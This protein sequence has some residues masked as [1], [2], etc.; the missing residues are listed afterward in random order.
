M[1]EGITAPGVGSLPTVDY[2]SELRQVTEERY[3]LPVKCHNC[4][5]R[6]VGE[7]PYGERR[8]D[9]GRCP[10]C[11]AWGFGF[12]WGDMQELYAPPS[13]EG[14]SVEPGPMAAT[15]E[16]LLELV[17]GLLALADA[18]E[19]A[20]VREAAKDAAH[21]ANTALRLLT[22]P[23]VL[24]AAPPDPGAL[25]ERGPGAHLSDRRGK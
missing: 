15:I 18:S 2:A 23:P 14:V 13:E 12:S 20:E 8:S 24:V 17:S 22:S 7:F 25:E 10:F 1:S 16:R 6:H 9:M 21:H 3:W 5:E 4:G 11:G 19:S